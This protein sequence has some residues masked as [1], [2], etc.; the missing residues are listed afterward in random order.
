MKLRTQLFSGNVL[1]FFL[2]IAL[3]SI[4]YIGVND[5]SETE[6]WVTHTHKVISEAHLLEK[7]II[8]MESG[9]LG[10]LIDA[11]DSFFTDYNQ[12]FD[13]YKITLSK[14]QDLVS[15]N[16]PQVERLGEINGL[17]NR[18]KLDAA[19][20]EIAMRR[21]VSTNQVDAD[22]LQRT[23]SQAVGKNILDEMRSI[24]A[25]MEADFRLD[26]NVRGEFLSQSIAKA[27]VDQETGE[28]GFL[29]TGEDAFLDPYLEGQH[30]LI[31][32]IA[33]LRKLTANAHDRV[34][35]DNDLRALERLWE[36]WLSTAGEPEIELRRQADAGQTEAVIEQALSKSTGKMTLD[37]MRVVTE[38]M[39]TAFLIAENEKARNLILR[40]SKAM[41]DAETGQR[42]FII[43]GQEEFLEPFTL[44][45]SAFSK[46]VND[47]R[48][49]NANS[50]DLPEMERSI[51]R[52]ENLANEW[53]EKAAKPEIAARRTMDASEATSKDIQALI[54][55]GTGTQLM[56][57]IRIKLSE[58][59]RIENDLL[60]K[61]TI[62]S[63]NSAKKIET[64][65][66]T[67][68]LIAIGLGLGGMFIL[69]RSILRQVG[70]EPIVIAEAT[71]RI[72]KGDLEVKLEGNTGI[73]A[74]VLDMLK[75]LRENRA[76]QKEVNWNRNG[77]A[78]LAD[79][80]QGEQDVSIL[81]Q[82]VVTLLSKLLGAQMASLYIAND[83]RQLLSLQGTYAS[84]S[85]A[86][87]KRE[88]KLGEGLVGQAGLEGDILSLSNIPE[89]YPKIHSSLGEAAPRAI[90]A[91]PFFED[92]VLVGVLEFA[93]L[94][95]FPENEKTF[96]DDALG[97]IAIAFSAAINRRRLLELLEETQAQSEELEQQ[98]SELRAS[99]EELE[100]KTEALD[101]QKKL[102]ENRTVE[103]ER[104]TLWLVAVS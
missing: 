42:S 99:N 68:S 32:N 101:L 31:G 88:I 19:E 22:T 78:H 70:G 73:V 18:W 36:T 85:I 71:D 74:S 56:D 52:L 63:A 89:D 13:R 7:N 44:G 5:L 25:N 46:A 64:A 96:L 9:E 27:M 86:D 98:S 6:F 67:G 40:A 29:I 38:R 62:E 34:D 66:I 57:T 10:F 24:I 90:L 50:Y 26:G 72:A 61:R 97:N 92:N 82:K 41:V 1:V 104:V 53:L 14:L 47:L 77:A 16:P 43:T 79:A 55:L 54:N 37:T 12:G 60:S 11:Q 76:L 102:I 65:V 48:R 8:D 17:V 39:D 103:V 15:D 83:S 3:A 91:A 23:L 51:D 93:S 28:R 59:I 75:A 100:E 49:L 30:S 69:N 35:T 87:L 81:A 4:T 2:I 45:R 21:K 94:H 95:P 20:P 84:E 58:F 33:D 80:L